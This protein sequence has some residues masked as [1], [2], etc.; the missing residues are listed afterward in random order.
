MARQIAMLANGNTPYHRHHAEFINGI[1]WGVEIF[2]LSV[3]LNPLLSKSSKFSM[4]LV[5]FFQEFCKISE[6]CDFQVP[7]L[8][9][10]DQ[11]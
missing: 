8:P 1:G 11:L 5:F 7:Q 9:L 4:S 6:I 3:S 2:L 10:Q